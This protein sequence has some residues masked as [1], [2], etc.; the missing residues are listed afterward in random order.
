MCPILGSELRSLSGGG[1]GN[2]SRVPVDTV[3]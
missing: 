2:I 1:G 3:D